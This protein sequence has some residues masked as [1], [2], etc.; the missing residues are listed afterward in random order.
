[1]EPRIGKIAARNAVFAAGYSLVFLHQLHQR[2]GRL[3]LATQLYVFV[4]MSLAVLL[5]TCWQANSR[6]K[7]WTWP[8]AF[9]GFSLSM[10]AVAV[11]A[12]ILIRTFR[13]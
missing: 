9:G 2:R 13:P 1:M 11:A 7:D 8:T 10:V 12:L 5:A 3:V 6:V 4:I